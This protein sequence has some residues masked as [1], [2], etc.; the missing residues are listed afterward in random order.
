MK[1][2][3][4]VG[5]LLITSILSFAQNTEEVMDE[6][7]R[8]ATGMQ[9]LQCEF[10]QTQTTAMLAEP[11]T[12][13]GMMY[14]MAPDRMR[15]EYLTPY[16][17]ALLVNGT[18]MTK[19]SDGKA[20]SLDSKNNRM[21]QGMINIIMGSASGKTLFD[22]TVFDI[23]MADDGDFWKADMT[24]KKRD[25]K[26]MFRQLVFRFD[27]NTKVI[28]SVELI[29]SGGD[30]TFIQFKNIKLDTAIDTLMFECNSIKQ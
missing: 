27:K 25:M 2:L 8:T 11:V 23:T 1:E 19:I 22:K 10:V 7:T 21:Y 6:L 4:T 9:Y 24:P 5:L 29:G 14:Y 30:V 18:V 17:L 28:N 13:T 3:L 16:S 12:S 26:R 15:W 20:E